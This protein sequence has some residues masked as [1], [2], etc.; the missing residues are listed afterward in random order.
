MTGIA[1]A[2][3]LIALAGCLPAQA[4]EPKDVI[5]FWTGELVDQPG[6][7]VEF[8]LAANGKAEM[9]S[10]EP[11]LDGGTFHSTA[12]GDWILKDDSLDINL[13]SGWTALDQEKPEAF[14]PDTANPPRH[15]SVHEENPRRMELT[16]CFNEEE[17]LVQDLIYGGPSARFTLP[18]ITS[19]SSARPAGR[20]ARVRRDRGNLS[21][22]VVFQGGIYDLR[23]AR[24]IPRG[25][26]GG[27]GGT[28][29]R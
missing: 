27:A 5:G 24:L 23:G 12:E 13:R 14:V 16:L 9:R 10:A 3:L 15:A 8:H 22:T 29:M 17:C 21:M 1:G 2:T 28:G 26:A 6:S 25:R 4:L 7:Q 20:L 11:V 19:N 18:A